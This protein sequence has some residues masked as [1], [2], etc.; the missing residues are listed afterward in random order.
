VYLDSDI[1]GLT[2]PGA[3]VRTLK[4]LHVNKFLYRR[5]G[6]EGYA[7]DLADLQARAGHTVN[8]LGMQH[9][10][11]PKLPYEEVFP[12]QIDF[13]PPPATTR[14][15]LAGF[16]RMI[17]SR[18]SMQAMVS[19]VDD[20]QPDIVHLH[21]I[22]HQL[23][24]SILRPL[25]K[26]NIATVMTVHDYK[27]VCPTYQLL[28]HG[29]VCEACVGS[30][31]FHAPARRC[32]SDSFVLSLT[33]AVESTV[34]RVS[35][36]YEP[37]HRFICP[38][39]FMRDRLAAGGVYPERLRWVP[40]FI[41]LETLEP[42]TAPGNGSVVVA[43]RLSYEKGIDTVIKAAGGL[44]EL[45]VEVAGDGP[46]RPELEALA[47]EVAPGRV[48]F[49]GRLEKADLLHLLRTATAVAVPSRWYENQPMAV[50]E[51]FACGL[52]VVGS[53][54]G[55]IPELIDAGVDGLLVPA[56]DVD[57]WR[58]AL[59]ELVT[60]PD[61]AFRMGQAARRKIETS[62]RPDVHLAAVGAVYEEALAAAAGKPIEQTAGVG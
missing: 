53:D 24:P 34:H 60:D 9:P 15:R 4:I 32:L 1:G 40:H 42:A 35:G 52:P 38:S 10:E 37:V 11:N 27:L 58:K 5:G 14:G 12:S 59:S 17:W 18:Q 47:E 48:H 44:P 30:H 49:H 46:I 16:G 25:S 41:D 19:V 39:R 20:F 3:A 8:F 21:N 50:L 36:A 55:G 23:S 45:R 2:R 7:Q 13:D 31:F 56:D 26:R 6:A 28:D 22:Y 62:F 51:A 61:Q 57:A 43:G 33:A 29:A 54:L